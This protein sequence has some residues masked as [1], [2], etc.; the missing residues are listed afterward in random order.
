MRHLFKFFTL[1]I[2]FLLIFTTQSYSATRLSV[3]GGHEMKKIN[4]IDT[5]NVD[6]I[7][8]K[9]PTDQYKGKLD[10][11]PRKEKFSFYT[12]RPY[13]GLTFNFSRMSDMQLKS[14]NK[15]TTEQDTFDFEFD[16]EIGYSA[17]LGVYSPN[18]LRVELEYSQVNHKIDK[19]C[20]RSTG[21]CVEVDKTSVLYSVKQQY[22]M[23]N[24]IMERGRYESK[25]MPYIGI[26]AGVMTSDLETSGTQ[27]YFSDDGLFAAQF[28]VGLSYKIQNA[29][30]A[31]LGYRLRRSDTGKSKDDTSSNTYVYKTDSPY[32]TQ[33]IDLGMR[34]MF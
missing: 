31:F 13:L 16:D 26:G 15:T 1:S 2:F 18:G 5:Y 19:Y 9:I 3:P 33:S 32:Q 30:Y 24:I 10:L 29:G 21:E 11:K 28:M 34:F 12:L 20:L 8:N 27:S 17:S 6:N 23:L 25:L 7:T 14:E 22:G 4:D